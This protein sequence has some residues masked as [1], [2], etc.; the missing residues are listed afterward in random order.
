MAEKCTKCGH[1]NTHKTTDEIY[2]LTGQ[3]HYCINCEVEFTP[4]DYEDNRES[5]LGLQTSRHRLNY[6][7]DE[8]YQERMEN[9]DN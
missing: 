1:T 2:Y 4:D 9:L 7:S 3:S 6:E 5:R 8:D